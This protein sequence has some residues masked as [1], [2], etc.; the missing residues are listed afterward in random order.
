MEVNIQEYISSGIVESYVLGLASPEEE[1]TFEKMCLMHP[2]LIA[3]RDEFERRLEEMAL[4]SAVTPPREIRE[5]IFSEIEIASGTSDIDTLGTQLFPNAREVEPELEVPVISIG[6]KYWAVA[7]VILL[8]GS[9]G[10]TLFYFNKYR[11]ANNRYQT[12]VEQQSDLAKQNQQA[13]SI[14]SEKENTIFMMKDTGMLVIRMPAVTGPATQDPI[15]PATIYW[16]KETKDVYLMVNKLPEPG[17]DKQYQ[18]WAIVNGQPVDAGVFDLTDPYT[19][20]KMKKINTAEA[21]AVTLERKG[22]S[23]KPSMQAIYAMGK[24]S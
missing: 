15:Q 24:V 8:I 23:P 12:L 16:D 14:L 17:L 2:E 3:A 13:K 22:G 6:W 11:E 4:T 18:L 7:S 1:A 9:I 21:F 10:L 5:R 19:R 20:L